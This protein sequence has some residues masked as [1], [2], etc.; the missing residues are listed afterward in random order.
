VEVHGNYKIILEQG[1][2]TKP[3]DELS[4]EEIK[5]L[6]FLIM[7]RVKQKARIHGLKPVVGTGLANYRSKNG[8]TITA[9]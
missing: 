4:I 1:A 3:F 9:N 6:G 2:A 8:R 5:Q 7:E